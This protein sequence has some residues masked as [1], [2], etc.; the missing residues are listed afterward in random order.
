MSTLAWFQGVTWAQGLVGAL[1]AFF[2]LGFFINT[3]AV[4][5]VGPEY[6]RWGY[7]DWFHFVSGGL[8]L[9]VALLLPSTLTR[10]FGILL[11]CAIMLAAMATVIYHREYPRAI[12]PFLVFSLLALVGWTLL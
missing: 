10:Q 6:E 12:P 11:G 1:A 3:F 2:V 7:P 8:D 5:K 9:V 4:S